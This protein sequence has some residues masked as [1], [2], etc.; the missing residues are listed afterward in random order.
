MLP[1]FFP[2]EFPPVLHGC[3]IE[4]FIGY[5]W[6]RWI[7]IRAGVYCPHLWAQLV[8]SGSF[9]FTSSEAFYTPLVE[10]K[11][12]LM[13]IFS[14][15]IMSFVRGIK[16]KHD[17]PITGII[18]QI[19]VNGQD[20]MTVQQLYFQTVLQHFHVNTYTARTKWPPICRPFQSI[21]V[22]NIW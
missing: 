22:M 2:E 19:H 8:K 4:I 17:I 3:K 9:W 12:S 20:F 5:L 7:V 11:I 6:M 1:K 21:F 15:G 18:L 14:W 16:V 13:L 10:L